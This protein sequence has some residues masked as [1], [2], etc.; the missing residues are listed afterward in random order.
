MNEAPYSELYIYYLKGRF[1]GRTAADPPLSSDAFIGNWEEEECSFLFF[2]EPADAAVKGLCATSDLALIDRFEMS[3]AEWQD[4][5]LAP[6]RAG[7][8]F[9]CPPWRDDGTPCGCRRID[10]DPGVV[11]GNGGHPTTRDCI[12]MIS[13]VLRSEPVNT[14]LDL[15]TGTGILA[16]VAARGGCDRV[17]AVDLNPLA[18]ETARRN[19]LLNGLESAVLTVRGRAEDWC[20]APAELLVA[21]IHAEVMEAV[22]RSTGFAEH[23]WFVLSG[24]LRTPA[25]KIANILAGLPL[26]VIERRVHDG[27]WHTFLARRAD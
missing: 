11:F 20:D 9:V 26:E 2:S 5:L 10:L 18:A 14:A 15:G 13:R 23:R 12:D 6:F 27:I 3:Y 19:A 16:L 25:R 22:V 24:L 8:L 7:D 4:G 1:G 21:N 17:L